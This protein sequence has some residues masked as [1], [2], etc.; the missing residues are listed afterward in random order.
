M[1]G[2]CPSVVLSLSGDHSG[3]GVTLPAAL[4]QE[5]LSWAILMLFI[6]SCFQLHDSS[7]LARVHRCDSDQSALLSQ[8]LSW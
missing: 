2:T 3:I 1:H 5:S 7:F 8:S 6:L 4:L